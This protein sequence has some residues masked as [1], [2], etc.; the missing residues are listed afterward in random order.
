MYPNY[1]TPQVVI[2]FVYYLVLDEYSSFAC[3]EESPQFEHVLV[4]LRSPTRFEMTHLRNY[5]NFFFYTEL[6]INDEIRD[7]A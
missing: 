6:T 3:S 1:V 4:K 7:L 2:I 5:P